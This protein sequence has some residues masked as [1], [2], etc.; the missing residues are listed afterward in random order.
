MR[1]AGPQA[2]KKHENAHLIYQKQLLSEGVVKRQQIDD[3][4]GNIAKILSAEYEQVNSPLQRSLRMS[5][6][7]TLQ[8][9]AC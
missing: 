8:S 2:I 3:I 5:R 4:H 6:G 7:H 1:G 9:L